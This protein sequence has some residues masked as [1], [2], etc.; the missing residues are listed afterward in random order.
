VITT[1]ILERDIISV[2][3]S[4]CKGLAQGLHVRKT[5]HTSLRGSLAPLL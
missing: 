5:T 1:V 2:A 3:L 4:K